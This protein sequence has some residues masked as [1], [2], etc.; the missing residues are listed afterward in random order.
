MGPRLDKVLSVARSM[1]PV[2]FGVAVIAVAIWFGARQGKEQSNAGFND[3]TT[4]AQAPPQ[5]PFKSDQ[6][7]A[8]TLSDKDAFAHSCGTCHTLRGAGVKGVIGPDLDKVSRK[9]T[10]ARVREQI[11]TGS[12]DSSMPANL[13]IGKDADRVARYVAR[14]AR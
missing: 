7:E 1:A 8:A 12:L 9:L 4:P 14:V 11:R 2:L 5:V 10:F 6:D 3:A 13:L